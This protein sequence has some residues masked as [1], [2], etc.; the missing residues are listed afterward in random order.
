MRGEDFASIDDYQNEQ[1]NQSAGMGS[2]AGIDSFSGNNQNNFSIGRDPSNLTDS[3][4]SGGSDLN[5]LFPSVTTSDFS[6]FSGIGGFPGS[7]S[8]ITNSSS[9][10]PTFAALGQ[11]SRGL[12]PRDLKGYQDTSFAKQNVDGIM[13]LRPNSLQQLNQP[14]VT[15]IHINRLVL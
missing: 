9:Y 15:V 1:S 4:I 5:Q 12:D 13:S 6:D 7:R 3:M 10:D 11:L 14:Q 8:N 2:G